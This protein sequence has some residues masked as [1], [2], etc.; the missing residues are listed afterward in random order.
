MTHPI[1]LTRFVG[2][3]VTLVAALWVSTSAAQIPPKH[4]PGAPS[5]ETVRAPKLN[6]GQPAVPKPE[7]EPKPDSRK[8]SDDDDAQP[9]PF[10]SNL[11]MGN[12]L[13]AREDGLNP[14]YVILPGDHVAV[15]TWGIVEMAEVLVV[16]SQGNIFLPQI[17]PVHLA[18][19]A[20]RNLS[21]VVREG[22]RKVYTSN[23]E[24]YTNLIT[25][26]PVAVFVTG[27]VERPGRYA[28]IP[29]DSL[30][31]FLDQAGG[32]DPELGSYRS[33][34]VLR[35][36][37]QLADVDLYDFILNGK[38]D[39]PQFEDGDVILVGRRGSVVELKGDVSRRAL[40]EFTADSFAGA[41]A[42]AVIPSAARATEVTVTGIRD[43][44]PISR[45]LSV[46]NFAQFPLQDG[47][48]ILLREDGRAPTI[49]VKLEGEFEG[50][51]LLAIKRGAR[52][53]DVL[54]YVPVDPAIADVDAIH[55]RR[56]SVAAA[57]K[58]SI[59][60]SLFRLERRALLALSQSTGESSIRAQEAELVLQ[61]AERARNIQPLGRVVAAHDGQLLNIILEEGDTI[62]IPGRNNI[63]RVG[64]EVMMAQAVMFQEGMRAREFIH[65]AGGYSERADKGKIII[66]HANAEVELGS[67]R[68]RI[69]PGDELL[70][71]P[72]VGKKIVQNVG[73]VTEIIYQI[74]VSAA[75]VL[76]LQK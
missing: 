44:V 47:D 61:F 4:P 66:L 40:L 21:G 65:R 51:T 5:S 14:D 73:D 2:L 25:A 22:V 48:S 67:R 16:D 52:L 35:N 50:P 1:K 24:V 17:G 28:G 69:Y 42:L 45:T 76:T 20:N 27:G 55:I 23:V 74:A 19:V 10:G 29:S 31:F 6:A 38:L 34:Q 11:F 46:A 75:V 59:S 8:S 49:L 60:D 57:Q 30:L 33:I 68:S 56:S 53:V 36:G 62:V 72:K 70:V 26:S 3:L 63:V 37:K 9:A 39:A 43:G 7:T 64:G 18:G 15:Q 41:D 54:N 12:F 32:I 13:R 71:P 58:D